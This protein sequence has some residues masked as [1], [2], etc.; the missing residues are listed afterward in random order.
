MQ[1]GARDIMMGCDLGCNLEKKKMRPPPDDGCAEAFANKPK[2]IGAQC[3]R[4][5]IE[6]ETCFSFDLKH[7]S[8]R[9]AE[10]ACTWKPLQ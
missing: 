5:T 4:L 3:G 10:D 6:N 9:C 7:S 8:R 2:L 1:K